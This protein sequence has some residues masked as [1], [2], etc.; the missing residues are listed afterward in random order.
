[1]RKVL[2]I[3]ASPRGHRS[4]SRRIAN[5]FIDKLMV[6]RP[7][8]QLEE[9]IL[10]SRLP[11]F[12]GPGVAAK[13][14]NGQ[15]VPL[16]PAE[17]EQWECAKSTWLH[18]QAADCYV[19]SVPMWNFSMPYEMKHYIDLITQPGWLFGVTPQGGYEGLMEGK[20]AFIAF[21]TGNNY[22]QEELKAYDHLRPYLRFWAN[23]IGL[24]MHEAT[25]H[26]TT[27]NVDHAQVYQECTAQIDGLLVNW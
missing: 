25:N 3:I 27:L 17:R 11:E 1:M 16:E 23:F 12:S 15:G 5:Y 22:D 19:F 20:K 4:H 24:E 7:N 8:I 21:A 6:Q 26:S 10:T 2:H 18:F 14:K 9:I 13:F